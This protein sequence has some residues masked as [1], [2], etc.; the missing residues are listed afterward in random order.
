LP[1]EL[2]LRCLL[3]ALFNLFDRWARV[4]PLW[5]REMLAPSEL[6]W[7]NN[8]EAGCATEFFSSLGGDTFCSIAFLAIIR[9]GLI[10]L[11]LIAARSNS[12]FE[13]GVEVS[14]YVVFAED[15]VVIVV[16]LGSGTLPERLGHLVG[17]VIVVIVA[18]YNRGNIFHDEFTVKEIIFKLVLAE[19]V[20]KEF[21]FVEFFAF[22][23]FDFVVVHGAPSTLIPSEGPHH[24]HI[25]N[26]VPGMWPGY[27]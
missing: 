6:P 19:F 24:R 23:W 11:F 15:V 25:G 10:V 4:I 3:E 18:V 27:A 9:L 22:N 7:M 8:H 26:L 21:L 5:A 16:V 20:L 17:V 14:L 13:D 2:L 1:D 12:V